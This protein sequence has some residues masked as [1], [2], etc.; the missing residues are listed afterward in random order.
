MSVSRIGENNPA[1]R[2]EVREKLRLAAL[3]R[4]A[5]KRGTEVP[6]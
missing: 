3:K 1:K 6:L 2:P 5:K 4:E